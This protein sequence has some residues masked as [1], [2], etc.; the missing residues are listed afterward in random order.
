MNVLANEN[1]PRLA[2][3][4]LRS[5]G[6]D[7]VWARTDMPGATDDVIL[8]RSQVE[9]R[10]VATFD[11]DFGELAFHWGLP[12]TCG[13]ALFRLHTQDPNYVAVRVLDAFAG[14]AGWIGHFAVVEDAR[15]RV[16]PLP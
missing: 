8:R 10:L 4:A 9:G 6:H 3:E 13:V 1:F 15:V 16:R 7:V 14:A 11:K 12:A 5:A 2:V